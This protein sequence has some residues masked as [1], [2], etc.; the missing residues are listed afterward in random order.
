MTTR[1]EIADRRWRRF[2]KCMEVWGFFLENGDGVIWIIVLFA[3]VVMFMGY[4]ITRFFVY[5]P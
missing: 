4:F 3:V 2:G 5:I 1:K